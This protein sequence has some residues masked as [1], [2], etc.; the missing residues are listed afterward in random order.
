MHFIDLTVIILYFIAVVSI[1]F[2]RSK[3]SAENSSNFI[4]AGRKLSLPAFIATLVTTWYG[5]ILGIGENTF[6]Y[7]IQTWFIFALPYYFFAI[8]F[9]MFIAPRIRNKQLISIPDHFNNKYG[10]TSG[11]IGGI[12]LLFL[13]SPAPYILSIGILLEYIF[14][15]SFIW[16]LIIATLFSLVYVWRGGFGAV[17]RT[18]IFEFI[19]MFS[20]FILLIIFAWL[21]IGS[22]FEVFSGLPK[23]H[24][25]VTGGKSVQYILVWFF[26]ALWTFIDPG[27]YQRCA[28]AKTSMTAKK[29]ILISVI[30]WFIF[31]ALTLT[32]GLYAR[33]AISSNQGL[34]AFPALGEFLLPPLFYGLFIVGLLATIMSTIDSLGFI[35]A[36]TFGRD[37]IG[38]MRINQN[39]S[40]SVSLTRIG[41][42]VMSII[43]IVLA[44]SFPSVVKLWYI[45]GSII[46][47]GLLIPFLLTFTKIK[48]KNRHGLI[49][50]IVPVITS[51][52]WFVLSIFNIQ[53]LIFNLEP[54][55]PG[56]ISSIILTTI[57]IGF[58]R[59]TINYDS[60][61]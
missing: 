13:A 11:I 61:E 12:F 50:L 58:N 55:Y 56:I 31:D 49:L 6:H 19:L 53:Y 25:S 33:V 18:D 36:F 26:I 57:I 43:A 46:V 38:R 20:G 4:L 24:L 32:S 51:L 9:A 5:G 15:I 23:E 42:I 28:A 35:S 59:T 45:V 10:K 2:F 7:G 3:K 44:Y 47:P 17:V 14:G 60:T 39:L 8:L 48:L 37:I 40:N 54:F 34:F 41:L 30:F 16:S 1:G 27:F 21:R 22:P 29:G 52:L